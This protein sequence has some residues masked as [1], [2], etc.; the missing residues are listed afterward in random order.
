MTDEIIASLDAQMTYLTREESRF[1][2]N[3]ATWLN[4]G[5]WQDD[6]PAAPGVILSPKTAGNAAAV[7]AFVERRGDG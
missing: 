5:R 6:P 7:R 4:Q 3:P 1:V 2:P